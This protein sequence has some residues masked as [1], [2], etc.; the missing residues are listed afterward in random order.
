MSIPILATKLYIPPTRPEVVNRERLLTHLNAGLARKLMLVSAPAGFGK[1]TLISSWLQEHLRQSSPPNPQSIQAAWLSL[2][3]ADNTPSRFLSYLIAALQTV[4]PQIGIELSALLGS[5]QPPPV[6][7]ILTTLLNEL[8]TVS[9]RIIL[10][11]D[12]Y[13]VVQTKMITDALAF[14]LDHLPPQLHLVI[15]TRED[16]PLPLARLRA[17]NQLTELRAADLRFTAAEAADFLNSIMGLQLSTAEIAALDTRTEGWIAGLQMAALSMQGRADRAGF[18]E[19]FAGSHRF[20]LD[21]LAEEVL[22]SLAE[23]TRDFLLQSA[24]LDRLRGPLCDA[25]TSRSD[26][27]M[28]LEQLERSNLFVIALDDQRRWY[29][30]HHLFADVLL[31]HLR[32]TAA[33]T[34]PALH[35][36][37]SRWY[38][39]HKFPAE[40]IRH[41]F[42]AKE[43]ARAADLVELAWPVLP[44]GH[45]PA[46]WRGWVE[47]LPDA[48]IRTR[49]VLSTGYAWTLLDSGEVETAAMCLDDAERWLALP[50]TISD[51]ADGD[52]ADQGVDISAMV[53]VNEKEFQT[54]SGTIASARAYMAQSAGDADAAIDH[55][56]HALTVLPK[57]EHYWRGSTSMFLGLA[58][59]ATGELVTAYRT[60]QVATTDLRDAGNNYLQL[61]G[62]VFLADIRLAQGH[63]HDALHGYERA[64]QLATAELSQLVAT[65]SNRANVSSNQPV[66]HGTV[67]LY[68]GL[69]EIYREWN[70]LETA[71]EHLDRGIARGEQPV[72]P[73][74]AARL[75]VAL[76]QVKIAQQAWTAALDL[77]DEAD[78]L[79]RRDASP[80][81]YSTSALRV[82]IWLKQGRIAAAKE[83][84]DARGEILEESPYLHEYEQI[85][86]VRVLLALHEQQN[87]VKQIEA[88]LEL[89]VHLLEMAETQGRTASIIELLLLQA[90]A[91]YAQGEITTAN[92]SLL[93]AL[94]LA[95]PEGYVRVFLDAGEAIHTLLADSLTQG[96]PARYVTDLLSTLQQ[97][98]GDV[99]A[100]DPNQLLIEPLSKREL[101]VLQLLAVGHTN[102]AVADDLVI[103]LSTVKKHTNSLFGKLGV[104]NRTQA[105]NRARELGIL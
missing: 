49:P 25:V 76:A 14:L 51:M 45:H 105:I 77:L 39:A 8:T 54:L 40:A 47:A 81:R 28:M 34:I 42:A 55:A 29:R 50:A 17:R 7:A 65:S 24:I 100:S 27:Q 67:N 18:I 61:V 91:Y 94:T 102:Q 2:D 70:E 97:E 99:T 92:T 101:E 38:E 88:A 98:A 89:L 4:E 90:S 60:M 66:L 52:T 73:G 20:V 72:S 16:P 30:Y 68:V 6:D 64:L 93:R 56:Q 46:T 79:Y 10:V 87:N 41:A 58:Q 78:R 31:A 36:R 44:H 26:S 32:S 83:W 1:T 23:S 69:G 96:A 53:V 74:S 103:A 95:E 63:L 48:L 84:V 19:A 33:E 75:H 85:T 86:V 21:Y 82:R 104:A 13:H 62:M 71:Q 3:E 35:Q 22:A 12:D 59:W 37:A 43:F 57:S 5:P 80:Q 9:G 11:L 15:T